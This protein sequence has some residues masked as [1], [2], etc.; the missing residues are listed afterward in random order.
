V[1]GRSLGDPSEARWPT[2]STW[3]FDYFNVPPDGLDLRLRVQGANPVK[4]IVVDRAIGLPSIS[5]MNLPPRP[6]DSMPQ[7]WGDETL[8][9]R[10]FVF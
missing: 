1:N 5:G 3:N 10:S 4:L 2:D 7:H 6:P 9:L 8:V